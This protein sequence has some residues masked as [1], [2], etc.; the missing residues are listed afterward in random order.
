MSELDKYLR[1]VIKNREDLESKRVSV[2]QL[3]QAE[4]MENYFNVCGSRIIQLTDLEDLTAVGIEVNIAV[5]GLD[6]YD[7]LLTSNGFL[8][9]KEILSGYVPEKTLETVFEILCYK[10]Q[11]TIQVNSMG[12]MLRNTKTVDLIKG[13]FN[14]TVWHRE[15]CRE[16]RSVNVPKWYVLELFY[17]SY[18]WQ[19]ILMIRKTAINIHDKFIYKRL[20]SKLIRAGIE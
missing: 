9:S 6:Q 7:V 3:L 8:E 2:L 12:Q 20:C 16:Q 19:A 17:R 5:A 4:N 14:M 13:I 11:V 15:K 10:E 18:F 1:L